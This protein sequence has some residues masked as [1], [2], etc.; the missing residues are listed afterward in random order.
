MTP[1]SEHTALLQRL[2]SP[3]SVVRVSVKKFRLVSFRLRVAASTSFGRES[4]RL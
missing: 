3:D 2:V 1:R 4:K